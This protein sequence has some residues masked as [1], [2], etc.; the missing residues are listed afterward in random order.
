VDRGGTV[1]LGW[2]SGASGASYR[3]FQRDVSVGQSYPAR[4]PYVVTGSSASLPLLH[5]DHRF[6]FAIASATPNGGNGPPSP[7]VG[8]TVLVV[9]PPPPTGLAAAADQSGGIMLRWAASADPVSYTIYQRD[10]TAG[11]TV[12]GRL[13]LTDP[14]QT[15][16]RT[17]PLTQGHTYEFTVTAN[18]GAGESTPSA[19]ASATA[20]AAPPPAPRAL[21]AV[22]SADGAVRLSWQAPPGG[23]S[24]SGS[25]G[26]GSARGVAR[27]VEP[28]TTLLYVVY[29]RD[30]TAGDAGFTGWAFPTAAVSVDADGLHS[31]HTYLLA[32]AARGP[33]GDGPMTPPVRVR[34]S[35]GLPQMVDALTSAAGDGEV[36]LTWSPVGGPHGA[37]L[38]YRRDLTLGDIDFTGLPLPV[39]G[40]HFTDHGVH[41][42]HLYLYR[43]AAG[44]AHGEGPPSPAVLAEP[45]P[46]P[47]PAPHDLH[48]LAAGG[49][50]TL[51]WTSVDVGD[52]Y[53][54]Y[55]RDVTRGEAF[56]RFP[57][58]VTSGMTFTD[59]FLTGGDTYQYE[60][61]ATN[62]AGEG[63]ASTAVTVMASSASGP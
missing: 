10:L 18:N 29:Q 40:N 1:H 14:F 61:T 39:V 5:N 8:V 51:T 13:G 9:R 38:I 12:P 60:I 53:F 55:R 2:T 15:A 19:P 50:V 16:A 47:P 32:V 24:G 4:L 58:P 63:L 17:D 31:G 3:V 6:E 57:L 27:A 54:V 43:V 48:A 25:P 45:L 62:L 49:S 36:G 33:G 7:I 21:R 44:N 56:Q 23:S 30:L 37:Y 28:V 52:F 11:A 26:A 20:H 42:G 41:N 22:V 35:G 46:P 34:V 59:G